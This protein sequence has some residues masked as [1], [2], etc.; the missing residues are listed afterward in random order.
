MISP[1]DRLRLSPALA[2]LP[3]VQWLMLMRYV[4][5]AADRYQAT[6]Y[7]YGS[8]ASDD[9]HAVTIRIS[10]SERAFVE[11]YGTSVIRWVDQGHTGPLTGLRHRWVND[12]AYQTERA[13]ALT[14]LALDVL[15]YPASSVDAETQGLRLDDIAPALPAASTP[16]TL[17]PEGV[18]CQCVITH[19]PDPGTKLN[20]HHIQPL[21]WGGSSTPD[22][23]IWICPTTH[24]LAHTLL[25]AY[26]KLGTEPSWEVRRHYPRLAQKL[27]A[28]AVERA[29]GIHPVYTTHHIKKG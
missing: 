24:E 16:E 11:R 15:I 28:Q 12:C 5:E 29:G 21:S 3:V 14:H 4:H 20:H 6:V 18:R 17:A 23:M 8:P 22:N 13:R 1:D 19:S 10:M 2:P 26:V 25:N 9:A 7:L 27:A